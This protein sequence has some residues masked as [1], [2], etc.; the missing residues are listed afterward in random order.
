MN[1]LL[2]GFVEWQGGHR[3]AGDRVLVADRSGDTTAYTL[4]HMEDAASCSSARAPP[5]TRA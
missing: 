3:R 4:S 2:E 1:T 5:S